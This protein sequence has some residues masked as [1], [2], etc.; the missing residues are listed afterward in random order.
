[1]KIPRFPHEVGE[2]RRKNFESVRF[3][4]FAIYSNLKRKADA[5]KKQEQEAKRKRPRR[6]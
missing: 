4:E 6:R 3:A 1:M 2:A 5:I